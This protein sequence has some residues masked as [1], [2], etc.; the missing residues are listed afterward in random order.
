MS[1]FVASLKQSGHL[2]Q[3]NFTIF[4]VGSRKREADDDYGSKGWEIFAPR[5]SIYGFDADADAC[6]EANAELVARKIN[7]MEK[8][9]PLALAKNSSESTLYVTKHPMCSSLYPPN[10]TFI[11]RFEQLPELASLDFSMEIETSTIDDFCRQEGITEIDFLQLDVQGAELQVLEGGAEIIAHSTLAIQ[12]EVEFSPIYKNQPLFSD[13]DSYVRKQG[14]ALFD[15]MPAYR[16]RARSPIRAANRFGQLLWGEAF[17]LRDLISE[18]L[19]IGLKTPEKIIKLACIADLVNFPDY[20]LELLEYITLEYGSNPNYN[21]ANNI[22]EILAQF[23]NLVQQGLNSL[24][25][26]QRIRDLLT[27]DYQNILEGEKSIEIKS[28]L[29]RVVS[30]ATTVDVFRSPH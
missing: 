6:E 15:L 23:P 10:E 3:V 30:H 5:L 25:I 26:I 28:S 14:F 1:I 9:I 22:V 12:S 11:A 21:L 18:N 20:S 8:H 7:W 17:Y 24:P 27:D 2:D 13:I 4:N 16:L 29:L 19:D